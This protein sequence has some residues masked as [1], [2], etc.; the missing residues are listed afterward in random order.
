MEREEILELFRKAG[1]FLEG[2]FL[3][4]SG[5]HS[6]YYVEKFRLLQFPKYVE[7]LVQ[8]MVAK[9]REK[10]VDLVVGPAVG[11]IILA[12]EAARQIGVPMA[13]TERD[14]GKMVF[15]RDFSIREGEHV[16]IVEDVITTG[17]SV[18]EVVK[19]VEEKGASVVG[20]AA[21][22]DR[23]GGKVTFNYPFQPLLQL[24][25][26]TYSPEECPLCQ[27]KIALQK[28]GSRYLR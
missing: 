18:Q 7:I 5:L 24:E 27:E 6:P 3:L 8:E 15:R 2:H 23:S 19:A 14:E 22:V 4:T 1:A 12:Y 28:R 11:G 16:L 21:L 9:F 13:F 20:I 26:A 10:K 17:T 25:I